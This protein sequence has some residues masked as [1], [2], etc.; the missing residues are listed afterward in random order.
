MGY[1]CP[2]TRP[3]CRRNQFE[4]EPLDLRWATS[5]K[6]FWQS[7]FEPKPWVLRWATPVKG[8]KEPG[9]ETFCSETSRPANQICFW[10]NW[11]LT[12]LGH[13]LVGRPV[14]AR[15]GRFGLASWLLK[16]AFGNLG[17]KFRWAKSWPAAVWSQFWAIWACQ[18]AI[19]IC[20][21]KPWDETLLGQ[22]LA[23]SLLEPIESYLELK[24]AVWTLGKSK[25]CPKPAPAQEG[26]LTQ[27]QAPETKLALKPPVLE[28]P[29]QEGAVRAE[30][31][32]LRVIFL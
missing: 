14:E 22:I 4:P 29:F 19:E 15:F 6:N 30:T 3:N 8:R 1:P 21:W 25:F 27:K 18:L 24:L 11:E 20:C 23:R 9:P 2:T 7:Q 12:L 5:V 32:G 31:Q 26:A 28:Q 17:K 16:F 10:K 13:I